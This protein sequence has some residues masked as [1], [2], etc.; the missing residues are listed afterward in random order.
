MNSFANSLFTVL[1]GWAR[2]LIQRIWI[3]ASAGRLNSFFVWIGDHW[4]IL[5]LALA[6]LGTAVDLVIWM[7]RW[8]P[9]LVWRSRARRFARMISQD[10]QTDRRLFRK[11]YMSGVDMEMPPEEEPPMQE[12]SPEEWDEAWQRPPQEAEL[13]YTP[14]I[15]DAPAA[16]AATGQTRQGRRRHFNK[17]PGYEPPPMVTESWLADVYRTD[18]PAARRR[19]RREKYDRKKPG[20]TDKLM[21]GDV[22]EDSL[23]DGLPPVVD[24]QRAFHEPVYPTQQAEPSAYTGWQRPRQ[25]TPTE[26]K[27][28]Q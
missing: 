19:R 1:F 22:E 7:I 11:G 10:T 16:S 17:A 14:E 28:S 5:A 8:R 6:V 12:P 2:A 4:M 9:Y 25:G 20:W 21:I 27:D 26:G 15:T 3:S 18:M 24:R 23:L 13:F